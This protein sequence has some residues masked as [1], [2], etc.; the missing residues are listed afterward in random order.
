[1]DHA[2]GAFL[3]VANLVI[4]RDPQL[5][6]SAELLSTPVANPQERAA[7]SALWRALS[8]QPQ[9][10]LRDIEKLQALEIAVRGLQAQ[11]QKNMSSIDNLNA[12]LEQAQAEKYANVLVYSLTA[13]L[14]AVLAV[15]AFLLRHRWLG[16]RGESSDKPW[17]RKKDDYENQQEAW[18][19]SSPSQ[20][21]YEPGPNR[22]DSISKSSLVDVDFDVDPD[23]LMTNPGGIRPV[24]VPG[25]AHSVPF[26]SRDKSDFGSSLMQ[27]TRAVKAEE[28]VDVQQQ[29][30]FFVSI[31]QHDQ[32]IEVLRTYI[33]ENQDTSALVY[34]DLFNLYYQLNQPADYERLRVSFNQRF[35]TQVPTF[36][37]YTDKNLGLESYQLALSRIEA[38]WHSPKV[39][40]IIED[41]LFRRPDTKAEA[42]NLEAYRELLLLYSVAKEI[43]NPEG[44]GAGTASRFDLPELPIDSSNSR[45]MTFM[46]TSIQPL[47]ATSV[48]AVQTLPVQPFV[49]S[50][51]PPGS[52]SVGLD[53][54][55]SHLSAPDEKSG[56]HS[57]TDAQFFAQYTANISA[58]LPPLDVAPLTPPKGAVATDNLIDF[59]DF[60]MPQVET[61]KPKLP[62]V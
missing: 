32:A 34:L 18:L 44:Q 3:I 4:E 58:T 41:S 22:I 7:A 40:E 15:M 19:D 25:F 38:L 54:D 20:E 35:N 31:G 48:A 5:K 9:D 50:V 57:A 39:L 11:S 46:P 26:G 29:A 53:I 10:I 60:D 2:V 37:L 61:G 12:K 49:P 1:M 43:I 45:R 27:P 21:Q 8:A 56:S 16:K 42:F 17:W 30:D 24:I 28:L 14:L 55:L 23:H 36:E 33:A 47:S 51:I 62:G 59:D 6:A 52:M 13:L